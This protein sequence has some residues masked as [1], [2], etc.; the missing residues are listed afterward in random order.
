MTGRPAPDRDGGVP[1]ILLIGNDEMTFVTQ[2]A[3]CD[4][5][6]N[7]TNLRDPT[8]AAIRTALGHR[9]DSAVVISKDDHVSLR[10]ALVV[11]GVRPG[12]PLV[13]TVFDHDVAVKL[14]GAVRN[15]AVISMA[16]VVVPSL[17][18]ACLDHSPLSLHRAPTGL[19]AVRA[20]TEGP[21][22]AAAGRVSRSPATRALT[23]LSGLLHPSE[24]SA[25]ILVGGLLGFFAIL[26]IDIAMTT[27]FLHETLGEAI[28][29]A[30]KTIV[31]VG[32]NP[33]VDEAPTWFRLFSAT[34]MVAGLAVGLDA[35]AR[36]S[37]RLARRD[38][39][40]RDTRRRRRPIQPEPGG[41]AS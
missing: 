3:L 12:I 17:A 11:E 38:H 15:V 4:A 6:A 20:G 8:D 1:H 22:I 7:V 23:T 18:A 14:E 19:R 13:V 35:V 39:L 27:V 32:P 5:G 26:V 2:R 10:S 16:D 36:R 34:M 21:E 31:T 29:T 41:P 28:Y 33:H 9:V 37:R 24:L 30:T 40:H 25:K